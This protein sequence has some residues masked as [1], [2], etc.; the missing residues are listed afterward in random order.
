MYGIVNRAIHDLVSKSFWEENWA[1]IKEKS[2]IGL[3]FF[4]CTQD[5]DNG[6]TYQLAG[7]TTAEVAMPVCDVLFGFGEWRFLKPA[8]LKYD[9][10][11]ET[12][13]QTLKKFLLNLPVFYYRF[14]MIYLKLTPPE[15][16]GCQLT[17]NSNW[18]HYRSKRIGLQEF[19]GKIISGQGTLYETLVD[20]DLLQS[21]DEGSDREIFQVSW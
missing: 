2:G 7:S 3:N 17:E 16:T 11:I 12:C 20:I 10:M 15:F 1:I 21:R 13:G 9:G 18:V 14:T 8:K 4:I 19:V 6:I 5:Y